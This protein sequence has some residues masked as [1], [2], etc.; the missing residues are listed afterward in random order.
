MFVWVFGFSFGVCAFT[1]IEFAHRVSKLI[2]IE[3]YNSGVLLYVTLDEYEKLA[4][5]CRWIYSRGNEWYYIRKTDFY[6]F[7]NK[8]RNWCY[9]EQTD[10]NMV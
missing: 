1:W 9:R 3:K 8:Y 4:Q 6:S 10:I 5:N 7:R 2:E